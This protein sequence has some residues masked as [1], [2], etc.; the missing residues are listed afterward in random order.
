MKLEGEI[1]CLNG[2]NERS[3]LVEGIQDKEYQTMITYIKPHIEK[4]GGVSLDF[5]EML[6]EDKSEMPGRLKKT[7]LLFVYNVD[8]FGE[9]IDPDEA[10]TCMRIM[11]ATMNSNSNHRQLLIA[12]PNAS[13]DYNSRKGYTYRD[14]HPLGN[15]CAFYRVENE[16][17]IRQNHPTEHR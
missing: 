5:L 11:S 14:N 7:R 1:L 10:T 8:L 6:K 15:W 3:A 2:Y 16:E 4:K 13:L 17:L 12:R 9:N